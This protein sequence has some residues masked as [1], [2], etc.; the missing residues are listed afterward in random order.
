MILTQE[1]PKW[2]GNCPLIFGWCRYNGRIYFADL[3]YEESEKAQ[4]PIFDLAYCATK[5][6]NGIFLLRREWDA[7]KFCRWSNYSNW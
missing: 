6:M 4:K 2:M 1:Y 7:K 3:N 5:A